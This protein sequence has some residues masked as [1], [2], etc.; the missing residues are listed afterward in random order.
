M[1]AA[2]S[3]GLTGGVHS[4][5]K[6]YQIFLTYKEFRVEQLQSLMTNGLLIYGDI[7][8]HFLIY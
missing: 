6:E 1:E 7:F 4:D 3:S 8:V 5:K 2:S